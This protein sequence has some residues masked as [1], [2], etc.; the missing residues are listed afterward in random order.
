MATALALLSALGFASAAVL[1]RLALQHLRP[2]ALTILSLLAS[3]AVMLTLTFLLYREAVLALV[4]VAFGWFALVGLLNYPVGQ[5]SR[6]L[7]IRFVGV[8]RTLP[9]VAIAPLIAALLSITLG[10]ETLTVSLGLGTMAIV[11]GVILILTER[12]GT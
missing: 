11:A 3:G 4:P 10:G 12:P 8:T 1:S 2:P 6:N 9:V 7:G 5:L